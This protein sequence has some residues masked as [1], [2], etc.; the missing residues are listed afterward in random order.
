M[1]ISS[2]A[3]ANYFYSSLDLLLKDAA[4]VVTNEILFIIFKIA[5]FFRWKICVLVTQKSSKIS[6][7]DRAK[8][9]KD[10]FSFLI[11]D[12]LGYRMSAIAF[13]EECDAFYPIIEVGGLFEI[14]GCGIAKQ[15]YPIT[16][17]SSNWQLNLSG[18]TEVIALIHPHYF[19]F[20]MFF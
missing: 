7:Y 16:G 12:R 1:R 2:C 17:I 19:V 8:N 4:D 10:R 5:N 13:S 11:V 18:F 20:Q 14:S 3:S 9:L 15:Q 6:Y